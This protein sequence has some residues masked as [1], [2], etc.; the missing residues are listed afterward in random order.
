MQIAVYFKVELFKVE[1]S[2]G[3]KVLSLVLVRHT[4]PNELQKRLKFEVHTW[5]LFE[6]AL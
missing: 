1:L 4:L 5:D 3:A 6:Y 2:R